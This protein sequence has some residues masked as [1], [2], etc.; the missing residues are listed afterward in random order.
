LD[1]AV[2]KDPGWHNPL[3]RQIIFKHGRV[4]PGPSVSIGPAG[5]EIF[6]KVLNWLKENHKSVSDLYPDFDPEIFMTSCETCGGRDIFHLH[7]VH[8]C[9]SEA[10]MMVC[11][12]CLIDAKTGGSA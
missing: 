9:G 2:A 6:K 11:Q 1:R 8:D 7:A 3:K 12:A 4:A 10:L 5:E